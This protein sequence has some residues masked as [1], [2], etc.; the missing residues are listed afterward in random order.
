MSGGS[1]A[2]AGG[3]KKHLE[4]GLVDNSTHMT[5]FNFMRNVG[6]GRVNIAW[7]CGE[8]VIGQQVVN[9]VICHQG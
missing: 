6:A 2:L 7:I 3:L 4:W 1:L 5:G 9:Q 8:R